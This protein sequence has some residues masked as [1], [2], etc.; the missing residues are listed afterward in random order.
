MIRGKGAQT[1]SAKA[2]DMDQTQTLMELGQKI[3]ALTLQVQALAQHADEQRRRQ[4]EWDDLKADL[5]PVIDDI[6]LVAVE[7]LGEIE[8][9]VR[10]EDML[11]LLKRLAR[12]T[13]NIENLL[14]QVE[15]L[16]DLAR[17]VTPIV[18][19]AVSTAVEKL[20]ALERRGYF[21]LFR[22]G[23]YVLDNIVDSFGPQDVRQLGDNVVTI[24]TTVKQ[25]TQPE[26]MG[27]MQNLA[28]A[29]RRVEAQPGEVD[30]SLRSIFRQLRDPQT[31][32]GLAMTLQ[33]LGA[34]GAEQP[35]ASNRT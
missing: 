31:R 33:M 25:M 20:D 16:S 28:G 6:Y 19:D 3:D 4:R 18:D 27:M 35:A 22:E 8:P 34:V 32:R 15:S 10:L 17:D 14:D 11:Y 24:L 9:Y 1:L 30:M 7:Q 26:I 13:R 29:V 21:K 23:Q 12:N 5:T 2:G